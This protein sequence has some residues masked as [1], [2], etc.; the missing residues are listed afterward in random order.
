[1]RGIGCRNSRGGGGGPAL[2]CGA[3][4][5]PKQPCFLA[6]SSSSVSPHPRLCLCLRSQPSSPLVENIVGTLGCSGPVSSF[7]HHEARSSSGSLLRSPAVGLR[8][9]DLL[10]QSARPQQR[11]HGSAGQDP[12]VRAHG[13]R[14]KTHTHA[15][16]RCVSRALLCLST[17]RKRVPKS[18]PRS[19]LTC[20]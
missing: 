1:M 10:L 2:V 4:R 17:S 11:N 3:A 12:R 5:R 14:P 8:A 7:Q 16:G 9:S 20:T 19:S 13:E 18:C 15:H 6:A